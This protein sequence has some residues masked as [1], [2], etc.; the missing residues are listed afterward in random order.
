MKITKNIPQKFKNWGHAVE[1]KIY[2]NLYKNPSKKLKIIG[3][4]GTDGKTTTCTMI[5]EILKEAGKKVGMITTLN[6]KFLDKEY[7]VGFHVTT[8]SPK[9]L[10]KFLNDMVKADLEYVV[11][12]TTS[13]GLDQCRVGGIKYSVAVF[14]N[15]T[16]EHLDYHKTYDNYLKAKG[17][18]I[19]Q[20]KKDG[21]CVLNKDD[22]SYEQ[23]KEIAIA[24]NIPIVTYG[25]E[26][27][28]IVKGV[29]Y[30]GG[31]VAFE[32]GLPAS[33]ESNEEMEVL[34][35]RQKQAQTNTLTQSQTQMQIQTQTT[36]TSNIFTIETEIYPELKGKKINLNLPG[37]YNI[38]NALSA[39]TTTARLGIDIEFISKALENIP[40]PEGRWEII[41][42]KPYQVVVDFA[43][44][45]NSL[46]EMLKLA[47]KNVKDKERVI[48][49]FGCAGLRDFY[50]R[51][52]MGEIA[53]RLADI[54]IITAEDPRTE[55]LSE[56]N[57]SIETGLLKN[58]GKKIDEN[59]FIIP[60]RKK[61]LDKA[62]E[63]AKKGDIVIATGK[64]HEK[65][66]N[67]DGKKEI[68]WNEQKILRDLLEKM[69]KSN[70]NKEKAPIKKRPTTLNNINKK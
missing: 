51:P 41:Q 9:L 40:T 10:Q 12:E 45:P 11:L 2:S 52:L 1:A 27:D 53:G 46:E 16:K 8:P 29:P 31:G 59:Y 69:G 38:S 30:G 19:S 48:V 21:F 68:P 56:I 42:K 15:I 37:Q 43:H 17:R 18:L 67:L 33:L 58:S 62:L 3:V 66:M 64:G 26:S 32:N 25:I 65:S 7:P 57:K 6:A 22:Y 47:R 13:H 49:V 50:K 61:A 35:Q 36:E 63:I 4:T 5:Y 44:T 60:D 28:A 54:V 24:Q 70:Q 14:T 20:T 55:D 23:L 39:I 34:D